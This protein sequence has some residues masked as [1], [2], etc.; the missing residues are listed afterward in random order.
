MSV[1]LVA[2]DGALAAGWAKAFRAQPGAIV[3]AWPDAIGDP[4][5]IT[6]ACVWR[7][8]HGLL[9]TLPNLKLIVNLGAGADYLLA[10]P[11]LPDVPIVRAADPDLSMRVTE[12]VVLHTLRYHRRQPLYEAQQRQRVWKEQPQPAASEVNVGVMGLGVIGTEAARV[13]ARIGFRVAGWSASAKTIDG[14]ETFHGAAGLDRF[15]ARTEILV[16][17]LPLTDATNGI[18]NRALFKKLRRDGAAGGAYLINAG[19]G[20]LQIDADILAALDD[21]TL[22]GATLDVFPQE[23][24]PSDSPMWAH[25]KVTVTP[26]NAGDILPE[27]LAAQVMRQIARLERGEPL[28]SLVD[29]KRGY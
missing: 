5:D 29:R 12:Y 1:I 20:P 21:G 9:A 27:L 16:C 10:D 2:V 25:P 19:R 13:L 15:L 23:P 26:H 8:P 18:L 11:K 28:E 22:A 4:K 17:L 3:R 24:L 6:V 7:A 14:V